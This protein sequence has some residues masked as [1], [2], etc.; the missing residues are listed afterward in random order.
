MVSPALHLLLNNPLIGRPIMRLS[1]ARSRYIYDLYYKR[2]LITREL[3][4]WLIKQGYADA[5]WA[6]SSSPTWERADQKPNSKVEKVGPSG[7]IALMIRQGY[8]RL[9]CVRCIATKDMNF[10]G[11]TCI[12][13]VPKAQLKKGIVVECP[14]CGE[15]NLNLRW[16][17]VNADTNRM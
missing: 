6:L 2:E 14:H 4:D 5:K 15:L 7:K 11:S 1:H 16:V 10:Q 3:Y 12:C 13:R 17:R 8:E 9:C